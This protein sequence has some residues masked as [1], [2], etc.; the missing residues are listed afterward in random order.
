MQYAATLAIDGSTS[1]LR[2]GLSANVQVVTGEASNALHVSAAA[3]TGTG[4]NRTVTVVNKD[5]STKVVTVTVGLQGDTDD[6]ITSGLT[7]GQQVQIK[8]VASTGSNGFPGGGFPG[9]GG[10][11]GRPGGGGAGGG[12]GR[13]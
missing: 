1:S 11:G 12:G 5:G 9:G 3:V 8:S 2:T 10:G 6:E 7:E 13:G 4:A